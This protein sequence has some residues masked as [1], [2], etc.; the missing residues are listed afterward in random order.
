MTVKKENKEK[1]KKLNEKLFFAGLS[2]TI[3][4][5][6]WSILNKMISNVVFAG[7]QSKLW[8]QVFVV[9]IYL[10]LALIGINMMI[11]SLYTIRRIKFIFILSL[12]FLGCYFFYYFFFL[13]GDSRFNLALRLFAI[14]FFFG[15][16]YNSLLIIFNTLKKG[17]KMFLEYKIDPK[18]KLTIVIMFFGTII[19]LIALF[20]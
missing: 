2:I 7:D 20:K 11:L 18:D 17:I 16:L 10:T 12:L 3:G 6:M 19:S 9:F 14:V 15:I 5:P 13:R 8:Y 1:P 4:A